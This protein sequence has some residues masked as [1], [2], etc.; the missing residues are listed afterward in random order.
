MIAWY[1]VALVT[2]NV[3]LFRSRQECNH[4]SHKRVPSI[5]LFTL[6][7][8]KERTALDLFRETA[9]VRQGNKSCDFYITHNYF[10]RSQYLQSS[11][12]QSC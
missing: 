5:H 1:V 11:H 2:F 12:L 4:G 3:L 7:A 6:Q 9:W 8:E 10:K